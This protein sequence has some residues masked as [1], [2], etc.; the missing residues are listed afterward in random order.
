MEKLINCDIIIDIAMIE[1][2]SGANQYFEIIFSTKDKI[3]YKLIFD[4]VWDMRYSI[5]NG[6]IDRFAQF[7]ENEKQKS[8][9]VLVEN[10]QY[11]KYFEKQVSGT[12]PLDKL[13]DYLLFDAV[14]TVLEILTNKKPVL[15]KM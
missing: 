4:F 14:D 5:E 7:T 11:I 13:K 9:I 1:N 8:S 6:Y 15:V 2:I 3:K 10:S 12:M